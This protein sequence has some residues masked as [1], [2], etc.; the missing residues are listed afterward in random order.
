MIEKSRKTAR[1]MARR[2]MEELR[3]QPKTLSKATTPSTVAIQPPPSHGVRGY[4]AKQYVANRVGLIT[5]TQRVHL[6]PQ[7]PFLR[8]HARTTANTKVEPPR[9]FTKERYCD[10]LLKA[11]KG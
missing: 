11:S 3:A 8:S 2:M 9:E 7:F 6:L 5:R 10:F 1:H 4:L